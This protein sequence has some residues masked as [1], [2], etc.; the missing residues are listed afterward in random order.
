MKKH[1][2]YIRLILLLA[3]LISLMSFANYRHAY[4][5]IN[6]VE[7][8]VFP[9]EELFVTEGEVQGLIFPDSVQEINLQSLNLSDLELQLITHDM[10]KEAEVY[11]D[12][13]GN[14]GIEVKQR[15]P[16][17][18]FFD[19]GFQYLDEEGKIMPLSINYSAR[20]PVAIGF[21]SKEIEMIYPLVKAVKNDHFLNQHVVGFNKEKDGVNI[22]F[23]EADFKVLFGRVDQIDLKFNNLKAFYLK[24]KKD[25]KLAT[26]K[27]VDLRFGNQVVCTKI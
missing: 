2:N 3:I 7:V 9:F 1:W 4:K 16:L 26:Y 24:A 13:N 8:E 15:R 21:S 18:R 6:A 10:I 5:T 20:V 11:Y 23:R 12:I 27:K 19:G 25:G 17:L 14:L 22:S